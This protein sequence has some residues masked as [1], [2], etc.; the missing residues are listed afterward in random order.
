[1]DRHV[2]RKVIAQP[3][4]PS[5]SGHA[6]GN[7]LLWFLAGLWL[8]NTA[9]AQGLMMVIGVVSIIG[10]IIIGTIFSALAALFITHWRMLV[11]LGVAA[12]F[13]SWMVVLY[14]REEQRKG[15]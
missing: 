7:G 12:L 3:V 15:V 9:V 11:I 8:G 2:T 6:A 1:M 14:I 10:I 5:K 13:I 4:S